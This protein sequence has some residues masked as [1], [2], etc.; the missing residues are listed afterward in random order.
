MVLNFDTIK[1]LNPPTAAPIAIQTSKAIG[2]SQSEY[3]RDGNILF[4]TSEDWSSEAQT[5]AQSPRQRPAERSVPVKTII[6]ATPSAMI[7]READCIRMF[8]MESRDRN[9]GLYINTTITNIRIMKLR[10][11]ES[12]ISPMLL[13]F[14][15]FIT[16]LSKRIS[17]QGS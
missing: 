7:R 10:A 16:F 15:V 12:M 13:L 3:A 4:I 6:P 9:L 2:I 17:P 14:F 8:T 5:Q 11:F 1:P